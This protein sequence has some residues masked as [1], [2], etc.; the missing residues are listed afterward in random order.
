MMPASPPQIARRHEAGEDRGRIVDGG[1]G[2]GPAGVRQRA[3]V[4]VEGQ[5][6][7]DTIGAGVVLEAADQ[8]IGELEVVDV[9]SVPLAVVSTPT[10]STDLIS[11]W[12]VRLG[13]APTRR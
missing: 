6:R 1:P 4:V 3:L 10:S 5:C 9:C 8:R 7:L 11:C 2:G 12:S 13:A